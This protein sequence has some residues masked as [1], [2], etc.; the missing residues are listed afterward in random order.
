MCVGEGEIEVFICV[1]FGGGGGEVFVC[2]WGGEIEVFVCVRGG[3]GC[4]CV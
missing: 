4:V 1:L 2:V 3:N